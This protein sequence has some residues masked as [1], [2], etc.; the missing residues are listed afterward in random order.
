MWHIRN[1][2][3]TGEYFL[4]GP[5]RTFPL[6]VLE[7]R[8]FSHKKPVFLAVETPIRYRLHNSK[9]GRSVKHKQILDDI[10]PNGD[11]EILFGHHIIK[12]DCKITP[13]I[14]GAVHFLMPL[15]RSV[16]TLRNSLDG[17]PLD[18][19]TVHFRRPTTCCIWDYSVNS[20]H[21]HC[22]GPI[23]KRHFPVFE[24][25]IVLY[26][27]PTLVMTVIMTP[28]GV[29]ERQ[30]TNHNDQIITINPVSTDRINV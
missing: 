1:R 29:P 7:V 10:W 8:L 21:L 15:H 4:R 6:S 23:R 18:F 27:S 28:H 5:F 17:T 2:S 12:Q 22:F 24:T 26:F 9:Y 16:R 20:V 30:F 13:E 11:N 19:R 14:P 3:T 25:E